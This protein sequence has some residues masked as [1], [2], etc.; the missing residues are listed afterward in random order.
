MAEKPDRA[1]DS[2]H[3]PTRG[4]TDR[5]TG[6]RQIIFAEPGYAKQVLSSQICCP[7]LW[8]LPAACGVCAGGSLAQL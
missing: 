4:R 6:L 7:A 2:K 5:P 8:L 3:P 1:L